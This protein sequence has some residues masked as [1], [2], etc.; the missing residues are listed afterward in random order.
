MKCANCGAP[1]TQL[2][3]SWACSR[4]CDIKPKTLGSTVTVPACYVGL[5]HDHKEVTGAG[6]ARVQLPEVIGLD[7]VIRFPVATGDWGKVNFFGFSY[8][9]KGEFFS[10][11][12]CANS[13][14][15]TS[16]CQLSMHIPSE[17]LHGAFG[18]LG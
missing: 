2:F 3:S 12:P 6:Y 16:R 18:C 10:V 11:A 7:Y 15:I 17:A 14:L 8:F 5:L 1:M 9:S 4:E 13:H